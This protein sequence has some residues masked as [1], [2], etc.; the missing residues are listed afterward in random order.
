MDSQRFG[1][2]I[3]ILAIGFMQWY[4][5][6]ARHFGGEGE[7]KVTIEK[8]REKLEQERLSHALARQQMREFKQAVAAIIPEIEDEDR[9]LYQV[10]N[11]ASIVV[12]PDLDKIKI[13]KA[14]TLFERGKERFRTGEY[15]R[16]NEIFNTLIRKYPDSIHVVESY[17]FYA[18]GHY[19]E[20]Q[21]EECLKTIDNMVSLFPEHELTGYSLLRMGQI[22][23]SR[24]RIEDAEQIYRTVLQNFNYGQ[25][26]EEAQRLLREITL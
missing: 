25:L 19:K 5:V 15:E 13:E 12:N 8:L 6:V 24:D 21:Y 22:L 4:Y 1:L 9:E 16:A 14:A 3:L 11:L 20:G 7:M 10:R 2:W 17:F 18:E 26:N 23:T